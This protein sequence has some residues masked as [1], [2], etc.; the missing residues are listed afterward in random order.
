[1]RVNEPI[2]NHEAPVPDGEPLVSR[3]DPGG[4]I[5]F[6]NH[7]FVEVSGFTEEELIGAPHNLVRHPHMP[8]QAFANLWATI[9]AGRPWDGLVKN[10]NKSGGYYWVRANVTPVVEG[11]KVTG[12]ISIRSKPTRSQTDHAEKAYADMHNGSARNIGLNDGELVR[13]GARAWLGGWAQ[14]VLGRLLAVMLAA[15]LAIVLVGWLGFGGMAASND[16]LRLVYERDLVAVNQL[17]S[18]LD[19]VRDNRNHIA[20]MTVA[21]DHGGAPNQI[22]GEREP[23][24]RAG[25]DQ[26]AELWRTYRAGERTAEQIGLADKFDSAYGALVREVIEPALGLVRSGDKPQLNVLFG[27][28][29]PSLFQAVFDANRTLVDSQIKT[30][31]AAYIRSAANLRWRVIAGSIGTFAVILA[32]AALGWTLLVAIR[33]CASDLERHFTAIVQGN[34]NTEIERPRAREFAHVTA[35]LRAMRA[36]LAFASW[37]RAEFE[38]RSELIRR[39]TVE[40]M[41]QTI[42]Q[43]TGAA[44]ELVADRTGAM[45]RDATAMATSAERVSTNAQHVSEAADHA[46]KNAQV[47]AAASEELAAAIHEVSAQ[48]EHASTVASGAA[49][50]GAEA[51][52]T[53]RSL[54]EAAERIG[55][56][57]RLIADIAA[58]TNLLALNATIEAARA[59]EAGRGFAVVAGEVKTL[60]AQ[61]AK[62]T[63]EI[64]QHI[65]GLRSATEAAVVSVEDIRHTLDEV[66][67][68]AVSVAAAI[69][70]QNATTKDI[71]RNVAESGAAVQEVTVRIAEVSSDAQATGD[72]ATHLR[73]TAGKVADDIAVLRGALVRTV[74]TATTEADRRLEVRTAVVEACTLTF[75]SD[76]RPMA[77]SLC[78][79][80]HGGAA[81]TLV[82]GGRATGNHGTIVLDRHR[83]ARAQFDVRSTNRD[84]SI[85][86]QFGAIEPAFEQALSTL[87]GPR[88]EARQAVAAA[89]PAIARAI[90]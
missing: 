65:N 5:V 61:T 21:L 56:V 55:A 7:V 88:R 68:V 33:R 78:D 44:V 17:R 49:V 6:A 25:M 4:N 72:Q 53:I 1:M 30:G 75:G 83:G 90:A 59:G 36:H 10:R 35:M 57:V 37:Q 46:M 79:L 70:E 9:K 71:A 41:A 34:M 51:Q 15:L 3:T 40:R 58:Q 47:V 38:R 13:T 54:S 73:A 82:G 87:L 20:Q 12:Y 62:A 26:I 64:S 42:E 16:A 63:E 50:K 23:L 11:G 28:Q 8:P 67:Q 81:V 85:H 19:R 52:G 29:A 66:A 77:G 18:V 24:V 2:T 89:G 48:V 76:A 45:A 80:S 84:G 86:V 14:S 31:E 32:V 60:A 22:L 74:R 39:E 43:E 27:R 69:E